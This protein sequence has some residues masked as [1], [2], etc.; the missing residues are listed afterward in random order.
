M[1]NIKMDIILAFVE[2]R[3]PEQERRT[4]WTR[5]DILSRMEDDDI[6]E[7]KSHIDN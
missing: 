1:Y 4:L 6:E 5:E 7:I 2:E 3:I